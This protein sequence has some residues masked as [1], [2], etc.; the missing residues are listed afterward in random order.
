MI[1]RVQK[2]LVVMLT[3]TFHLLINKVCVFSC[4][5]IDGV[6]LAFPVTGEHDDSL[7]LHLLRY[8]PSDIL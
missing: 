2:D 6:P 4:V 7:R 1:Q 3:A 5:D 8:L